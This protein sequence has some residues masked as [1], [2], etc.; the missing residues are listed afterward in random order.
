MSGMSVDMK[1]NIETRG[2]YSQ[3]PKVLQHSTSPELLAYPGLGIV[4]IEFL[5][6][7]LE[8]PCNRSLGD[9]I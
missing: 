6:N 4:C 8:A 3:I 1:V 5:D 7:E 9:K 2:T